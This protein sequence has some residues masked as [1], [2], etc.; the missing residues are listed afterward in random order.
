MATELVNSLRELP[1]TDLETLDSC[2]QDIYPNIFVSLQVFET[3]R[4]SVAFTERSFS[5]LHRQKNWMRIRMGE[6]RLCDL[7][8]LHTHRDIMLNIDKV[9]DRFANSGNRMLDFVI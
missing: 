5:T 9:I 2:D 3:L 6:G 4:V 1:K 8:F 7:C